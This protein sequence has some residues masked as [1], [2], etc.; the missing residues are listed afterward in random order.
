MQQEQKSD[1][2]EAKFEAM[3]EQLEAETQARV[4]EDGDIHVNV[5]LLHEASSMKIVNLVEKVCE[6][7]YKLQKAAQA[8]G[9]IQ[10]E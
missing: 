2:H 6:L 5:E 8:D 1:A 4:K 3:K 9:N 7:E 10:K